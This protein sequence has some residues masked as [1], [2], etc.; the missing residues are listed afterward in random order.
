M[1]IHG[2]GDSRLGLFCGRNGI[3][4]D[5]LR[6]CIHDMGHASGECALWQSRIGRGRVYLFGWFLDDIR[7]CR[8]WNGLYWLGLYVGRPYL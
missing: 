8:D 2:W 1:V 5:V 7:R 3:G 6:W 4:F